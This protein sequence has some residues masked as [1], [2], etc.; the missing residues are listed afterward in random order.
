MRGALVVRAHQVRLRSGSAF[1]SD[2]LLMAEADGLSAQR[3]A[4]GGK[5]DESGRNTSSAHILYRSD[6]D[7]SYQRLALR[8]RPRT[9]RARS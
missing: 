4:E 6:H 1:G 8:V 2:I 5:P 3:T 9:A 7:E